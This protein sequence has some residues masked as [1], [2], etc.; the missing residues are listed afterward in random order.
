M[1]DEDFEKDL[2][3]A[4]PKVKHASP[5]D[6]VRLL[7]E[8]YTIPNIVL[9]AI[10]DRGEDLAQWGIETIVDGETKTYKNAVFVVRELT[11]QQVKEAARESTE[12]DS[13][14]AQVKLALVKFGAMD[15]EGRE[16]DL[17]K[18]L[19]A[20]G[21]MLHMLLLAASNNIVFGGSQGGFMS[22]MAGSLSQGKR[23]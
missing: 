7:R 14:I 5:R 20:G 3:G 2:E 9:E 15:V 22:Q 17:D 23:V 11:T 13:E 16:F 19:A 21:Y 18:I 6:R 12:E 1:Q 4:S 8:Q 10:A